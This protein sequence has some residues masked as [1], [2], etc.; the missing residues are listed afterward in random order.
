VTSASGARAFWS[1]KLAVAFSSLPPASTFPPLQQP[2]SGGAERVLRRYVEQAKDL[3]ISE[4]L[5]A[6]DLGFTVNVGD[7][8]NETTVE[9]NFST[10]ERVRGLTAGFRQLYSPE[11]PASFQKAMNT[12]Q[13]AVR[14]EKSANGVVQ[15]AALGEWGTATGELRG[16]WL[17][18]LAQARF[19]P[20]GIPAAVPTQSPEEVISVFL[21][22]DHLHWDRKAKQ[23]AEWAKDPVLDA[24]YQLH[25][26]GA[27]A[28]LGWLYVGFAEL[29][30]RANGW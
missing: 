5:N 1:L 7:G 4:V 10:R 29:V 14:G 26:L 23:R 8:G 30:E 16:K 13:L 24:Y 19:L 18:A 28:G 20:P 3:A 12:M 11:E 9:S 25:F 21:Y 27:V 22:G 6:T 2:A 15:L 17:D